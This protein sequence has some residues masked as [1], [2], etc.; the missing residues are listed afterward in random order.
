VLKDV[1]LLGKT[2]EGSAAASKGNRFDVA[3]EKAAKVLHLWQNAASSS[4]AKLVYR[5]RKG[6]QEES[7]IPKAAA[8]GLSS[9]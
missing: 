3:M 5:R 7:V 1:V 8:A 6:V 4:S 2:A 9:C